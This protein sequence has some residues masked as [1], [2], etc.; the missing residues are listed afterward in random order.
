MEDENDLST[1]EEDLEEDEETDDE[2]DISKENEDDTS[3]FSKKTDADSKPSSK[4][5]K[6][7]RKQPGH[8]RNIKSKYDT[9]EDLNPEAVSAQTEELERIRRLELQ[10]SILK[11][12]KSS[13]EGGTSSGIGKESVLKRLVGAS[14]AAKH[15]YTNAYLETV[16]LIS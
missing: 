6:R 8:R 15:V 16:I 3:S 4:K 2:E 10:Q 5:R 9:V 13:A 1:S 11:M 12:E 14:M 7:K